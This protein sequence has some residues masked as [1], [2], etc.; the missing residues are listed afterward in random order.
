M[1]RPPWESAAA[2]TSMAWAIWG[3]ARFTAGATLVSSALMMRVISK[4]DLRSR[5]AEAGLGCSVA[6][7]DV[8]RFTRF[9]PHAF[10]LAGCEKQI[11][12]FPADD[13]WQSVGES[14]T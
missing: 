12:R 4:E 6:R 1:R 13:N 9:A 8:G 2:I 14:R 5:S 7:L 3:R 11:A 10:R